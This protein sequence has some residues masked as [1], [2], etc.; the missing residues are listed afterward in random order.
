MT[1]DRL[2]A[3]TCAWFK[4]K[5][6]FCVQVKLLLDTNSFLRGIVCDVKSSKIK[7]DY[8]KTYEFMFHIVFILMTDYYFDKNPLIMNPTKNEPS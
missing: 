4:I 6:T 2:M 8:T 5:N 1:L 7:K 3:M